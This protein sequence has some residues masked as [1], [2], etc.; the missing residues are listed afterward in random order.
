MAFVLHTFSPP[1][2]PN[3]GYRRD[4]KPKLL[5]VDFGDGY[6]QRAADGINNN[7]R[8]YSLT[9][10]HLHDDEKDAIEGFLTARNGLESFF[11]QFPDENAPRA[12]VCEAW[13]VTLVNDT[14]Y[15]ISAEFMEVFD[16]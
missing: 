6:A 3:P 2:D 14:V 8:K 12:Y 10:T 7:A 9:W 15:T 11:Y 4:L 16:L 1:V 5:K 13:T